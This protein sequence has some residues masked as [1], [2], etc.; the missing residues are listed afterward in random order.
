LI[1]EGDNKMIGRIDEQPTPL[2]HKIHDKRIGK[3]RRKIHTMLDPDKD[4]RKGDRRKR[5][6][7]NKLTILEVNKNRQLRN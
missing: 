3:D 7:I 5:G 4:R 6:C 1:A 2:D